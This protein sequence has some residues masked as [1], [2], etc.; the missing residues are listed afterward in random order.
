MEGRGGGEGR[1][2]EGEGEGEIDMEGVEVETRK[3]EEGEMNGEE[4][5][6][7]RVKKGVKNRRT[8]KR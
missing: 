4:G 5:W 6:R 2:G 3:G 7:G 8:L 1:R